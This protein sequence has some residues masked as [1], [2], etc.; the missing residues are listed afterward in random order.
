MLTEAFIKRISQEVQIGRC[1]WLLSSV[2]LSKVISSLL[3]LCCCLVASA[4]IGVYDIRCEYRENPLGM[5]ILNPRLSWKIRV[6][7]NDHK[8]MQHAY[9]L[10]VAASV[11]DLERASKRLWDSNKVTSDRSHL[12]DY[13]GPS[14]E[15]RKRY[16][17]RVKIWDNHN[18]ESEWSD[19][20]YW[21]MG[22]LDSTEWSAK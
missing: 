12:V 19:P 20:A 6:P 1:P 18:R 2:V 13:G 17:W 4:Q 11:S 5:D 8:V 16:Y 3:S 14:L 22:L 15:S 21:E 9:Q 7:P 10:Q